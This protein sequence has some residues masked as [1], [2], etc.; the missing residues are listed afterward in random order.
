M[1]DDALKTYDETFLYSKNPIKLAINVDRRPN[2]IDNS[3]TDVNL[4]K[5]INKFQDLLGEK[6]IYRIHLRFLINLDLINFPIS[7]NTRYTFTLE[8]DLSSSFESKKVHPISEPDA[9]IIIFERPF[10]S[11]PDIKLNENFEVYFN[12]VLRSKKVLRKGIK[13][14]HYQLP[15]D[16]NV[17][18]QSLVLN[19]V[20]DKR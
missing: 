19:F 17:G 15:F 2:N 5:Q 16:F 14:T 6:K 7:F 1:P 9:K 18:L 4:N 8:W 12:T 3:R 20:G 10:I 11:Y 13:M